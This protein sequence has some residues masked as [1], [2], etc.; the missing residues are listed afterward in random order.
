[1][2]KLLFFLLFPFLILYIPIKYYRKNMPIPVMI[3]K[4]MAYSSYGP[5]MMAYIMIGVGGF[6]HLAY[7]NAFPREVGIMFS[8]AIL[9]AFCNVGKSMQWLAYLRSHI[10]ASA[11]LMVFILVSAF[12][13]H[14]LALD[15]TLSF[16]LVCALFLPGEKI[17]DYDE[18]SSLATNEKFINAYFA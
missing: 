5:K 17:R 14:M 15:I 3:W 18:F 11:A 1:M 10:R 6:F 12:F 16:V 7:F 2:I 13:P 4:R 8:T 9:V